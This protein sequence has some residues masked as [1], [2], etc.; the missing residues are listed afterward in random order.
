M[1]S[2]SY[3][4]SGLTGMTDVAGHTT[5]YVYT[6]DNLTETTDPTGRKTRYSYDANKRKLSETVNN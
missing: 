3:D 2:Y 5:S 4:S 1:T 6:G